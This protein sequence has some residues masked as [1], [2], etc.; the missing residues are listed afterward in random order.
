MTRQY[1]A[2]AFFRVMV[3]K[4]GLHMKRIALLAVLFAGVC[5][6]AVAGTPSTWS[7]FVSNWFLVPQFP[8]DTFTPEISALTPGTAITVTR[9]EMVA[10]NG[11]VDVSTGVPQACTTSPSLTIQGG[12]TT[13]TLPM[14]APPQ[15]VLDSGT[16]HSDTNSG[17]LS[18]AFAAGTRITLTVNQGDANCF[19]PGNV[20][21]TI[22]YHSSDQN[23]Q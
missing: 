15:S 7:A 6:C 13:Y 12:T 16:S 21:I 10:Q 23:Q 9:I 4:K 11:P 20:N 8:G 18:L 1:F 5:V 3:S 19:K 17:P 14:A 22:Q 2:I